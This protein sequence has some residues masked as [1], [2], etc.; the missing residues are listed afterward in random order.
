MMDEALK[1]SYIP[2]D[3]YFLELEGRKVFNVPGASG[4]IS[5]S[6]IMYLIQKLPDNYGAGRDL[7]RA[8]LHEEDGG[9]WYAIEG[10]IP[11]MDVSEKELC[12]D[13]AEK[14]RAAVRALK[15]W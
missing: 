12:S 5:S 11:R 13:L 10:D 8:G 14:I 15:G 4:G 3:L 7:G 6:Y 9:R 1:D 2:K